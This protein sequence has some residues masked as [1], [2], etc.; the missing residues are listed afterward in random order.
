MTENISEV[1]S[2]DLNWIDSS[3]TLV[4]LIINSILIV[5]LLLMLIYINSARLCRCFRV[6]GR[7]LGLNY[8]SVKQRVKKVNSKRIQKN[9]KEYS[10]SMNKF[11]LCLQRYGAREDFLNSESLNKKEKLT[12]SSKV[13]ANETVVL[14]EANEPVADLDND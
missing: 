4:L 13:N 7:G 14:I 9:S 3:T 1:Q 10:E 8:N 2:C 11:K 6:S 12:K 5:T